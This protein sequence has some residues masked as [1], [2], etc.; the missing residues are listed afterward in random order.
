MSTGLDVPLAMSAMHLDLEKL[1][2]ELVNSLLP[3]FTVKICV[4]FMFSLGYGGGYNE[5]GTVEYKEREESDDEFDEF[6]RIKKK[7]R[8]ADA[9]AEKVMLQ[10]SCI[11]DYFTKYGH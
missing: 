5:R 10:F 7:F 11:S 2:K 9:V 6:G 4:I 8:K 1:K 3:Y